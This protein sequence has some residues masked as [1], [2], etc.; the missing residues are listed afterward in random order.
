[1]IVSGLKSIWPNLPFQSEETNLPDVDVKEPVPK[2]N[3]EVMKVAERD[4][5]VPMS[6]CSVVWMCAHELVYIV[7]TLTL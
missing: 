6:M 7:D 5:E 1:M 3:E 4:E 2:F